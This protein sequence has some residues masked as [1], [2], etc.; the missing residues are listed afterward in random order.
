MLQRQI[1]NR[2]TTRVLAREEWEGAVSAPKSAV[3]ASYDQIEATY[4][5]FARM[6][7][8][9]LNLK[10]N[11]AKVRESAGA[12]T[13][14]Q[15][16]ALN[17][18]RWLAQRGGLFLTEII[19]GPVEYKD[20][21]TEDKE[22]QE[23]ANDW[24]PEGRLKQ[25]NSLKA[26]ALKINGEVVAAEYHCHK[27]KSPDGIKKHLYEKGGAAFGVMFGLGAKTVGFAR[28]KTNLVQQGSETGAAIVNDQVNPK[29][30]EAKKGP[31]DTA[32]DKQVKD[33][34]EYGTDMKDTASTSYDLA[35]GKLHAIY[36]KTRP[37]Y[38]SFQGALSTFYSDRGT[39]A[40]NRADGMMGELEALGVMVGALDKMETDALEFLLLCAFLGVKGQSAAL[41]KLSASIE[42]GM[43]TSVEVAVDVLAGSLL[44]GG[45]SA[46][47]KLKGIK[48]KPNVLMDPTP[49]ARVI[50]PLLEIGKAGAK[51]ATKK[52]GDR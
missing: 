45:T 31:V 32:V 10:V 4:V 20:K 42:K 29:A 16:G 35:A 41:N 36:L 51:E 49:G 50:E 17:Y 6:K 22:K 34:T 9:S 14:A 7:A 37:P 21:A 15:V 52:D 40:F 39:S 3:L 27:L 19:Q 30:G 2:A 46:A 47:G 28:D 18:D 13:K 44:G 48:I 25:F 1:G 33:F 8:R 43:V 5:S 11:D 24:G 26:R 23:A 12:A 38:N